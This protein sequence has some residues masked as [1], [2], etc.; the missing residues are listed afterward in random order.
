MRGYKGKDLNKSKSPTYSNFFPV[1][2]EP[3]AP[4]AL[5]EQVILRIPRRKEVEKQRKTK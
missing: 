1:W 3:A 2:P 4:N 5:L